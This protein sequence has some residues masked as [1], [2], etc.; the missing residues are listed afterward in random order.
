MSKTNASTEIIPSSA[1]T[2]K[3][4]MGSSEAHMHLQ[5]IANGKASPQPSV[6]R[7]LEEVAAQKLSQ[8]K[9]TK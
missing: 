9:P 6:I 2:V 1:E 7:A 5:H 4:S 3:I 8:F